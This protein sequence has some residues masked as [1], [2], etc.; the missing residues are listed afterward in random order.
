MTK[1]W[2]C[3]TIL[4]EG[5]ILSPIHINRKGCVFVPENVDHEIIKML[6]K[7]TETCTRLSA[8]TEQHDNMLKDHEERVRN[9]EKKPMT[10]FKIII[11]SV[12]TALATAI[13]TIIITGV[14]K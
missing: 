4:S 9:I 7:L 3:D 8:I 5:F 14:I 11:T 6:S 1:L 13:A 12:V 10:L 2:I